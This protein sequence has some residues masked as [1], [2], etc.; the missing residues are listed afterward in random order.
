MLRWGRGLT[1]AALRIDWLASIRVGG[2]VRSSIVLVPDFGRERCCRQQATG[3][4]CDHE[5]YVPYT[6][7]VQPFLR[8]A[9][10]V[11]SAP[12]PCM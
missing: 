2:K 6:D 5:S 7:C 10:C 11:L 12:Y 3:S 9:S 4:D 1:C 8:P